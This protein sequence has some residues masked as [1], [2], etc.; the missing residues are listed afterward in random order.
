MID[1]DSKTWAKPATGQY[2]QQQ[3]VKSLTS[4]YTS[5]SNIIKSRTYLLIVI[6]IH[7]CPKAYQNL[8]LH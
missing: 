5:Y 4:E 1:G 7:V 2:S 6:V 3:N 8:S